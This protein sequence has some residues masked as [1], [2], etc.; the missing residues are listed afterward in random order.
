[1][2]N[3]Y[4]GKILRVNLTTHTISTIPT[5]R[6]I[7]W[8]GGHGMG[9]AIFWDLVKD[10]TISGF[11]PANVVTIMTSPLSGTLV[12]A[13]SGRTEVQGIGVQSTPEWF[14]RS[15]FGGRFG[16]ML[17]YAGW[18]GIVLEGRSKN[19]VWID[20]RNGE[21]M[22]R[23]AQSLWGMDTWKTQEEIW[24]YVGWKRGKPSWIA[25]SEADSGEQST[26]Q[27]AVLAIGPAGENLCRIGC[28]VHDAGNAAGQGG[29]GGVWG[30]KNLKAVSVIGTGSIAIAD[31]GGLLNAR[32]WSK[33]FYSADTT[34]PEKER[35]F[36]DSGL[37]PVGFDSPFVPVLFW[38]QQ[39]EK[40]LQA[41][42]GCHS[43]CRMRTGNGLGNESSCAESIYYTPYDID[44]HNGPLIRTAMYL[45]E[46][47]GQKGAANFVSLR[48]GNQTDVSYKATDLLQ[49]YGINAFEMTFGLMYLRAL[50][51]M[52]ELGP[53]KRIA[54]DLDF[55]RMG[56]MD[57]AENLTKM[58]AY[59]RGIGDDIAEG[60]YRAAKKWGRL[61]QD[62][63]SGLLSYPYWGLPDH[64]DPRT[65]LEWGY[66]SVMG[67]RD[68]N[69]H[70]FNFLYWMPSIA[71]LSKKEPPIS[72][73]AVV[74]ICVDKM[75]P[76]DPDPMMLDFSS[77][78]MYSKNIAKLVSW[79]RHYTRFWKESAMF[80][81]LRYA[82]FF[83]KFAPDNK[84]LTGEGEPRF[85]NA[86]TGSNVGFIDG[87]TLGQ[88][89]WNLDHAIWTLQGRH[90]DM[91]R[92]SSYIHNKPLTNAMLGIYCMPTCKDGIWEY[93]DV[94][95][96]YI[97]TAGFEE[98]KTHFYQ[99]EGWDP[100][101]G[102]PT[103]KTLASLELG[104]VAEELARHQ[105]L[106]KG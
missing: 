2:S 26:Q 3:G 16:S 29:F 89:I 65:E 24:K 95:N 18:D 5:N 80:C 32:L 41:C 72:A 63:A 84:G 82:D 81:D 8:G 73:E 40:R 31:P 27:P 53:G 1:M 45:L 14:T 10:K 43:G 11:D 96:R 56:E 104:H 66:G 49:Q 97:E 51:K 17:K 23:D 7:R 25:L 70:D 85:Y 99:Q 68:I 87:M 105:K 100:D 90:R 37:H 9:A 64:Y 12:P 13:A 44:K 20:I 62:I 35:Y 15:N 77:E 30:S 19:P 75:K 4:A 94:S 74:K 42:F 88:K 55:S 34:D 101:T 79:H 6:Y 98:W 28:L 57:F 50:H 92:F 36:D 71:K 83:N 46:K 61:D 21:A 76:F 86:V 106:G 58:V 60:F 78:N 93:Q 48:W 69:E 33:K 67:D 102:Y 52:G 22:I 54:C 39:K 91:V 59:R 47:I 103:L 38:Q